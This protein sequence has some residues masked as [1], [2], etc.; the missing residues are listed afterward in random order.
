M[1]ELPEV[2]T[3]RRQ[4][5]P[6][7]AGRTIE[8]AE[9]LDARWTRP[10]PPGPVED[11]LTGAVVENVLRRG[12]YLVWEL[13]GGRFLIMNLRMTGTLLF[14]PVMDPPHTRVRFEL[15]GGHRLVY[16]DPR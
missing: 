8:R 7:L 10:D 16:V 3:I 14:D 15:E 9:I 2:E 11:E 13:S 1:P 4:L 5:A 12:K 6:S